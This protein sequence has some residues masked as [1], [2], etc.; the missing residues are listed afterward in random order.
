MPLQPMPQA[1][2]FLESAW[3]ST[4]SPAHSVRPGLHTH[5]RFTQSRVASHALLQLPQ[6]AGFAARSSQP[7][8]QSSVPK[9]HSHFPPEHSVP[10]SHTVSQSPQCWSSDRVLKQPSGH[11]T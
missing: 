11:S 6:R 7:F 2:Q 4:H 3:V 1:P 8:P 9:A 10:F 5:W